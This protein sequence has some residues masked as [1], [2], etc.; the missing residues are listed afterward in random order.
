MDWKREVFTMDP[1][2]SV[3]VTEAFCRMYKKKKIYRAKR[4]VNWCCH[5]KTCI[6]NIEVNTVDLT[7]KTKIKIPGVNKE[8]TFGKETTPPLA[9]YISFQLCRFAIACVPVEFKKAYV[10]IKCKYLY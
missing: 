1:K 4:L 9:I 2:L 5:L 3:A 7:G 10:F 8:Y 6:S